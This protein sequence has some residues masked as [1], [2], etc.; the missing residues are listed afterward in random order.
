MKPYMEERIYESANIILEEKLTVRE[1]AKIMKVSKS[2]THRDLVERLYELDK[3]LHSEVQEALQD[4]KKIGV[5]RGGMTTR[6]LYKAKCMGL[7][8][9]K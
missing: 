4:N 6:N 7:N 3:N 9:S 8:D 1:I 5:M 2:T